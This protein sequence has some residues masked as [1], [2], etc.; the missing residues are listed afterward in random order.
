MILDLKS[1]SNRY[2][3]PTNPSGAPSASSAAHTSRIAPAKPSQSS[4]DVHHPPLIRNA[5][6]VC[7]LSKPMACKAPSCDSFDVEQAAPVET[8]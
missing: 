5:R 8:W 4:A 2:C 7:P 6:P 1:L 3:K